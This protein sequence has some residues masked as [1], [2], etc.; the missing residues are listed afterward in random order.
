MYLKSLVVKIIEDP[1]YALER[2]SSKLAYRL[3]DFLVTLSP[4]QTSSE[5]IVNQQEIRVVG[6]RR[7]GNHLIIRWIEKQLIGVIVHLNNIPVDENP[8]RFIY[9]HAQSQRISY[10]QYQGEEGL[11][12]LQR[13]ARGG[14]ERKDCLIYSYE[15]YGLDYLTNTM[16]ERNRE[17]YFGKSAERY[18][19]LILRDPFN[20]L[21]SRFKRDQMLAM[22]VKNFNKTVTDMW[23]TYAKEYLGETEYLKNN[24]IVVNYNRF[25]TD[26]DYRKKIASQ[27]KLKFD[28]SGIDEVCNIGSGSSF[29]K[30][31][32][33]GQGRKM[34][35]LN[36]WRHFSED[37]S[38]RILL[39]NEELIEYS[40]RIFGHIPGTES[41]R[42]R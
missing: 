24:K 41:L 18:D 36:R 9:N 19:L 7:S 27:L 17:R 5:E 10:P 33:K 11:Q 29:D 38:Y 16:V 12:R 4:W 13:E 14:F 34:D 8:Y 21:A 25:I 39:D 30:L 15:D 28:D 22:E 26:V 40:K 20:M 23:I 2:A 31:K 32:F 35:V 3:E 42:I 1:S 6:L 37:M